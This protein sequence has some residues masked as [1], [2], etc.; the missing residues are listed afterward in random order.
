M[1]LLYYAVT[2][3]IIWG[4]ISLYL[5]I[6]SYKIKSLSKIQPEL[7]TSP[8]SVSVIVAVRN[9]EDNLENALETI[10]RLTY[11]NYSILLIDDRSTDRTPQIVDRF[12]ERYTFVKAV[13]LKQLPQAWLGKNYAMYKGYML[14]DAEW[15]LFTDADIEYQPESLTKA[16]NYAIKNQLDHLTVFPEV[17]SRSTLFNGI[18]DT[19]RMMLEIRLRPWN[20]INAKSKAYIGVGAFNLIKRSAYEIA[21]THARLPLRPDDD[22]KL[23]EQ[24]KIAGLKQDV[25]Y[26]R[27]ELKLEW[28]TSVQQFIQG[29]MKNMFSTYDY[30]VAKAMPSAF[31][32]LL[33]F[34]LPVPLLLTGDLLEKAMAIII[35]LFQCILFQYRKESSGKLWH[36]LL[37]PYAAVIVLYIILLSTYRTLQQKG[38]YWRESFYPLTELKKNVEK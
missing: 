8:P 10:C 31:L 27:S 21:G 18:M 17:R 13:H 3:T 9:E 1:I 16:I 23:G 2:T 14:S 30:K 5:L 33:I 19:F 32:T 20:A 35:L 29:L 38:I 25:L 22:L 34:V 26:G 7:S 11:P 36:V 4:F 6:N 37:I 28:Y 15:I 12:A 24:V